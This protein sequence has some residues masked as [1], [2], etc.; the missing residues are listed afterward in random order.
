MSTVKLGTTFRGSEN[1][2]EPDMQY[3]RQTLGEALV[4]WAVW[5]IAWVVKEFIKRQKHNHEQK[6]TLLELRAWV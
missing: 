3:H 4:P 1:N 5:P 2:P 6:L